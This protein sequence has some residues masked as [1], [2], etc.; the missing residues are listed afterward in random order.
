MRSGITWLIL[1]LLAFVVVSTLIAALVGLWADRIAW[2]AT[3]PGWLPIGSPP[4]ASSK[5]AGI[6]I[7]ESAFESPPTVYVETTDHQL[8]F[9]EASSSSL[10]RWRAVAGDS[11]PPTGSWLDTPCHLGQYSFIPP[12][13]GNVIDCAEYLPVYFQENP[14]AQ[15][16][17]YVLLEDGTVWLWKR[18]EPYVSLAF[19][20]AFWGCLVGIVLGLVFLGW[21][22]LRRKT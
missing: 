11:A 20:Y 18:T 17:Q 14:E 15:I 19:I 5:I 6:A 4:S 16:R 3:R 1:T 10:D 21:F 12:I 13:T 8:W 7:P 2:D 22:L 9:Y